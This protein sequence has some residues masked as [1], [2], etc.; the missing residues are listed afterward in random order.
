[1]RL[2]RLND[3]GSGGGDYKEKSIYVVG[4]RTVDGMVERLTSYENL[5]EALDVGCGPGYFSEALAH[6]SCRLV[7]VDISEEMVE[8]ARSRLSSLPHVT[9]EL[10][11]CHSLPYDSKSFDTVSMSNILHVV[12]D[13][14][15]AVNEA[16]RV[17]RPGGRLI[18]FDVTLHG[19]NLFQRIA[20]GIRYIRAFGPPPR[21][22]NSGLTTDI[23]R[24]WVEDAGL[25]VVTS[26]LFGAP[27][28]CIHVCASKLA[29]P[30]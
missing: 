30:E 23:V 25:A 12:S 1:M 27:M 5:G 4:T 19:A 13:P 22:N 14:Q 17:L 2:G 20:A 7:C 29:E 24:Q 3:W 11:G 18:V 9:V 6:R 8:L 21:T 16:S 26:E 10:A 15:A 28:R